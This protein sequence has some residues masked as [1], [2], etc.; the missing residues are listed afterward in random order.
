MTNSDCVNTTGCCSQ[1]FCTDKKICL[2]GSKIKGEYCD[3]HSECKTKLYCINNQCVDNYFAFLPRDVIV[4]VI[5]IAVAIVVLSI[6]IYCCFKLCGGKSNQSQIQGSGSG[7]G[8]RKNSIEGSPKGRT[9]A[10][11]L[12]PN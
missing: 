12:D 7:G 1:G 11:L 3:V 4:L 10:S 9:T 5:I 6:I 8:K 2:S